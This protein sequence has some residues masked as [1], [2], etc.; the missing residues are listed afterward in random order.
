MQHVYL[1]KKERRPVNSLISRSHENGFAYGH[2]P[3][4]NRP[5]K[6]VRRMSHWAQSEIRS[7]ISGGS[8]TALARGRDSGHHAGRPG[9]RGWDL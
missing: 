9:L 6:G 8:R 1:S 2:V 4:S 3:T 7:Q 5:V